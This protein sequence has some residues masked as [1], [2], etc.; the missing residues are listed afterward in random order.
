MIVITYHTILKTTGEPYTGARAVCEITH[1]QDD[2]SAWMRWNP[3]TGEWQEANVEIPM[4]NIG[5]ALWEYRFE[6]DTPGEYYYVN[7][8]VYP[9]LDVAKQSLVI[10]SPEIPNILPEVDDLV[11][12][13]QLKH[14]YFPMLAPTGDEE[15]KHEALLTFCEDRIEEAAARVRRQIGAYAES[16]DPD[17]IAEVRQS[18]L[19]LT[20]A[21]LWQII[22][23]VMVSY[24]E[25]SLPPEFVDPSAAERIRDYYERSALEILVQY[26]AS[27][28]AS[29]Y[30]GDFKSGGAQRHPGPLG[31]GY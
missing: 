28:G 26:D 15:E 25:E 14:D 4:V 20:L 13:G 27:P 3:E 12:E 2:V 17:V 21:R 9:N 1:W 18:I 29:S 30:A 7:C 22:L 24:D 5:T 10:R 11:I 19:F 23:D 6:H 16:D 8:W 31:V